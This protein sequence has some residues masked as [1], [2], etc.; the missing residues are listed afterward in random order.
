M[1]R[2]LLFL[3]VTLAVPG[4]TQQGLST[5]GATAV[6]RETSRLV[7][8]N[9]VFADKVDGIVARLDKE[10]ANGRYAVTDPQE[11]A[12]RL[13]ED[14]RSVTSDKHMSVKFSPEQAA[15]LRGPR[16]PG[17]DAFRQQQ[18]T[19]SNYGI[20]E[21]RVLPGNV[22]YVNISP[23]FLWDPSNSPPAL[24]A[25]MR[26]LGGGDA[27]ILDI[28][29]NGGGSP[30]TVRY[31]VSHFMDPGQKLMTYRIGPEGTSE[32]RTGTVP[33][34]KLPA[35]PLYLLTS[36]RSASAAEEFASHIKNFK[37]GKLVGATTAGAGHRNSLFGTPE[38][39]VISVSVGTAIHPVTNTGWEGT[40]V[41]PD[42]EVPVADALDA[43][44]ADA[45]KGL[46]AKATGPQK[47]ELQ[48]ALDALTAKKQ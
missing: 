3:L 6:V 36:P 33:A 2:T 44:H 47:V 45:L 9:Y 10:L 20:L 11:L 7:R 24:D 43:A 25:A 32:S 41:A 31:I 18:M 19:S 26:F 38:G 29:T 23:G 14:L 40:G 4:V 28:R 35:R 21:M 15:G 16:V 5:E 46:L 1:F 8:E 13:T 22:R 17:G 34:G 42:V 27:Y 39:F 30:A 12:T 37:L 48:K